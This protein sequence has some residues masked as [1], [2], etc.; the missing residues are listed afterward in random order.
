MNKLGDRFRQCPE[1]KNHVFHDH[2]A[3]C[4]RCR[5]ADRTGEDLF[6]SP[7]GQQFALDPIAA[8]SESLEKRLDAFRPY[9]LM[10][11]ADG[12]FTVEEGQQLKDLESKLQIPP[13]DVEKAI[14]NE[15]K[16]LQVKSATSN[17]GQPRLEVSRTNFEFQTLRAGTI[18]QDKFI[19]NNVGGGTLQGPIKSNRK[20]LKPRQSAID[21]SRHRQEI[22][23]SVDAS[24]LPLGF[25]DRGEVVIHSN[26]GTVVVSIDMSVEVPES[27]IGR[28]RKALFR[29]GFLLGGV[30]GYALFQLLPDNSSR[31]VVS[32]I[33]GWIG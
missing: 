19:I 9:L 23:F 8:A 29:V 4:P 22:T 30:F 3:S 18:G 16:K 24:G 31:L 7:F 13:K 10:A 21:A 1:N 28:F 12:V 5:V 32:G 6:P 11:F 26:G 25:R 27:A 33:A 20:W 15:A 17:V 14:Q 2:L